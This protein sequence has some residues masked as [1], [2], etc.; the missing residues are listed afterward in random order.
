M[1]YT[2]DA[3]RLLCPM[4]VI[5]TQDRIAA[6]QPGDILEVVA[7][8]PGVIND[9]PAWCRIN[10][11]KVLATREERGEVVLEIEVGDES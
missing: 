7:T 9:I 1:K 2:L 10:G 11:H 6:L 4:P 3:R 5:R 8:D